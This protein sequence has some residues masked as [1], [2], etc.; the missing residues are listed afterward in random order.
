MRDK[1]QDTLAGVN[2]SLTT[3]DVGDVKPC[4]WCHC[5]DDLQIMDDHIA[6]AFAR[7][8]VWCANCAVT[9]PRA[10]SEEEAWNLWNNRE[11]TT[12]CS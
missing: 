2:V 1:D 12:N 9:G 11:M 5:N 3:T 10:K 6:A 8:G 7:F 4:P